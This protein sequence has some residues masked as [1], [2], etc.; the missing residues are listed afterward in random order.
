MCDEDMDG[1]R[2]KD[3]LEAKVRQFE[4]IDFME[5]DPVC[6]P[7]RFSRQ[8]DRE[9]AGFFAALLAWGNRKAIINSC[10]RLL[11]SMDNAP[12]DFILNHHD[13]DL[14][15]LSGFVHRT[16]M[17]TDLLFLIAFLKQHYLKFST[18]ESAFSQFLH[19]N[20]TSVQEA[21]AGFHR[22]VFAPSW[23]PVRTRKHIATPEKNS[24]CKRLNMYLRWMV[25]RNSVVDF[26]V[27]QTINPA[28]LCCPLDLHVGRVARELGILNRKQ[29]DWKAVMALTE[30]LRMLDAADPVKYDFA[31]FGMG[32]EGKMADF[33]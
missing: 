21:L 19:P 17:A 20:S 24:A 27:W 8:Q 9:I 28:L 15:P 11:I 30:N 26:G 33:F 3:L 31:L 6:I 1:D 4:R 23:A 2:L 7:H 32:I 25:R 14:R 29:D 10:N 22:Y 16:F 5:H 13:A 18:L 12:Y